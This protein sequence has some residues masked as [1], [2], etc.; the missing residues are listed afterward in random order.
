MTPITPI[1]APPLS[2]L[3]NAAYMAGLW[4][5][6]D[7]VG[8]EEAEAFASIER[9]VRH[10]LEQLGETESRSRA[11]HGTVRRAARIPRCPR[12]CG[13]GDRGPT[14]GKRLEGA[15]SHRGGQLRM[16]VHGYLL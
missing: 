11:C 10:A 16:R 14:F 4:A 15:Y 3:K 6:S 12:C 9:L 7:F 13:C 5:L 8:K 1:T 2:D